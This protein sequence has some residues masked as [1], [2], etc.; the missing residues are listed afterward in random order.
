MEDGC[1][2]YVKIQTFSEFGE[3]LATH[4]F[5]GPNAQ[6][7]PFMI[8]NGDK[9]PYAKGN[10]QKAWSHAWDTFAHKAKVWFVSD[11]ENN[12]G[13]FT[14]EVSET[15]RENPCKT[16]ATASTLATISTSATSTPSPRRRSAPR[17]A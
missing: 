5:C 8:M 6:D 9:F 17:S 10:G 2:D 14:L 15:L 7:D 11:A 13:G 16:R 12:G 1:D 3:E 4:Y